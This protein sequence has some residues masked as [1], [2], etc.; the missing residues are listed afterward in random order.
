MTTKIPPPELF[1]VNVEAA[2]LAALYPDV[3]PDCLPELIRRARLGI[4]RLRGYAG[5]LP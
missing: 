4:A 1:S 2:K 5:P 3:D